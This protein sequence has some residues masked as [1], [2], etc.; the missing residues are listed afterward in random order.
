MVII[1]FKGVGYMLYTASDAID[2]AYRIIGKTAASYLGN[3]NDVQRF[4]TMA[5]DIKELYRSAV[6]NKI[7]SVEEFESLFNNFQ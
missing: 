4:R 3:P 6:K 5:M 1:N 7:K 2:L